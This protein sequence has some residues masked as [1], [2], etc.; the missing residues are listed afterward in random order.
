MMSD[1]I[2]AC[3]TRVVVTGLGAISPL[4]NNVQETWDRLI[5]GQSGIARISQELDGKR[6]G[7]INS[8]VDIAGLV[9]DFDSSKFLTAKILRRIHR[10][11]V[12]STIAFLEALYHAGIIT[13]TN[14]LGTGQPQLIGVDRHRIGIRIGTGIGGGSVIA[15]TEDV[16]RDEGDQRISPFAMLRL[17]TERVATV[18]SILLGIKGPV[19]SVVA[20]CASG[21]IAIGDAVDKIRLGKADVMIAGGTEAAI[22]RVGLGAFNAMRALARNNDNPKFASRPFNRGVEGFVMGEGAGMLVLEDLAHAKARGAES[23]ILAEVIGYADTADA[24]H[25]TDPSD[26]GE[27]AVRAMR[28]A[29]EQ[30][31][32]DPAEVDYINAHG[33][34]TPKGDEIELQALREVFGKHLK[35]ISVSSTKSATGHLLGAA[36]GLEAVI[37]IKAIQE[38]IVPPTLNLHDPIQPDLDLTPLQARKRQVNVAMS[39]SFGFGGLNSVLIFRRY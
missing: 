27:G 15:E 10:S 26:Q 14:L 39:N 3:K 33:T 35:N 6:V 38:G 1:S 16:I 19:S 5:S 29:L 34:S 21:S 20:A 2:E 36:G 22:H 24:Y 30:A 37:C 18:P 13:V 32:I 25:D 7:A 11:A 8:T 31:E 9:K 4:G 28:L 23:R 17:L 12:F